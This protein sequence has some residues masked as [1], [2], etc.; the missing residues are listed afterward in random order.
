MSENTDDRCEDGEQDDDE[1]IIVVI[2]IREVIIVI[3]GEVA[4]QHNTIDLMCCF[5]TV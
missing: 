1:S 2:L 5:K 4:R 3:R